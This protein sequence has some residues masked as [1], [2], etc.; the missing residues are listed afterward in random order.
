[1]LLSQNQI[2]LQKKVDIYD[3]YRNIRE[4]TN[5]KKESYEILL[6]KIY[7]KIQKA[8]DNNSYTCY[9]EIPT[10]IVGYP[11]Y[12]LNRCIAYIISQI[13][14]SGFIAKFV[15]PN[16]IYI[17]W[18]PTDIK[19]EKNKFINDKKLM[20][21]EIIKDEEIINLPNK[22]ILNLSIPNNT[23]SIQLPINTNFTNNHKIAS[24]LKNNDNN[25]INHTNELDHF[26]SNSI[27]NNLNQNYFD[28]S[29]IIPTQFPT[30]LP[31]PISTNKKLEYHP[32]NLKYD[33]YKL[34]LPMYNESLKNNY[35]NIKTHPFI[36]ITKKFNSNG[37]YI[38]DLS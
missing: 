1:M 38:L 19:L 22:K 20:L 37:K 13:R 14:Q 36:G 18:N 24:M 11:I 16:S 3:I 5:K 32:D 17:S 12:N 10:F 31:S 27:K 23:T 7:K 30:K 8:A 35:D 21:E 15:N 28:N 25:I 9:Y 2:Q 4:K 34:T 33:P 26:F 29:S 6:E